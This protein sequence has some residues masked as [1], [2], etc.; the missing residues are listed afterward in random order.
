[1]LQ[2]KIE[3]GRIKKISL[4]CQNQHS[5]KMKPNNIAVTH[6]ISCNLGL[7]KYQY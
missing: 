4:L 5:K 6:P 2:L 3:Y 1:M 7:Y